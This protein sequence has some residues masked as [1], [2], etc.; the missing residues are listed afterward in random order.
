M[1]DPTQKKLFCT[2]QGLSLLQEGTGVRPYLSGERFWEGRHPELSG[3]Q[4]AG[5]RWEGIG[6]GELVEGLTAGGAFRRL[7]VV[8]AAGLGKSTNLG[9][10]AKELARSAARQLPFLFSLDD[11]ALPDN[12]KDLWERALP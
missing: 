9:W 2:A 5:L 8:C 3:T 7:A 6:R 4:E 12:Q 10:L 1:P 11:G